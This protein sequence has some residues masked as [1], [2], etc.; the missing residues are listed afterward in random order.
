MV[1]IFSKNDYLY[2]I[3][4]SINIKSHYYG[5]VRQHSELYF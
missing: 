4:L 1:G 2:T 3:K 5:S